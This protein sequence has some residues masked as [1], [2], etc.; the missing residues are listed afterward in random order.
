MEKLHEESAREQAERV[1]EMNSALSSAVSKRFRENQRLLREVADHRIHRQNI[2]LSMFWRLTRPLRKVFGEV[3]GASSHARVIEEGGF[4]NSLVSKVFTPRSGGVMP[5]EGPSFSI[6]MLTKNTAEADLIE[7]VESVV[8]QSY[9]RWELLI[10]DNGSTDRICKA[11][12]NEIARADDRITVRLGAE[13]ALPAC[14]ALASG[15]YVV[16]LQESQLLAAGALSALAEALGRNSEAREIRGNCE[17]L[18][19]GEPSGAFRAIRRSSA[20]G[21]STVEAEGVVCY[22]RP[23]MVAAPHEEPDPLNEDQACMRFWAFHRAAGLLR[24]SYCAY[25]QLI[26]EAG[27]EADNRKLVEES[28][29]WRMSGPLRRTLTKNPRMLRGVRPVAGRI[30]RKVRGG[31]T[32]SPVSSAHPIDCHG[33]PGRLSQAKERQL[34]EVALR[35]PANA[36]VAEEG[37]LSPTFSVIVP[38][39]NTPEAYLREC[40]ESV[41]NQTY[42]RWELCLWDDGSTKPDVARVLKEYE[43][44]DPRIKCFTNNPNQGIAGASESCF[45]ASTGEFLA[46]LDNDDI[47]MP[48]ALS[49]IVAALRENPDADYLYTDHAMMMGD[50]RVTYASLKRDWSPE[51]FLS[52]NYIVHLKA[53]RRTVFEKAGTFRGMDNMITDL[54]LTIRMLEAGAKIVHVPEIAYGWRIHEASVADS[55][56]RKPEIHRQALAAISKH[57]ADDGVPAKLTYPPQLQFFGVG[58]YKLEFDKAALKKSAIVVPVRG[59]RILES[60][61]FDSLADTDIDQIP[62]VHFIAL[63]QEL[64]P[65]HRKRTHMHF[66]P[67]Q[68]E[69]DEIMRGIDAEALVFVSDSARFSSANW[70]REVLGFLAVSPSIGAVGGMVLD[71][72]LNVEE[73]GTLLKPGLP[74]MYKGQPSC[75]T[76][77]WFENTL[78]TNVEAVSSLL[79]AT[80]KS[81]YEQ[82]GGMPVHEY[83]DNA[84]VAY[85][86][87]LRMAGYRLVLNPWSKIVTLR[88][89]KVRADLEQRLKEQFGE[90]CLNDRYYHPQFDGGG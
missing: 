6:L 38:C 66:A 11:L 12:L 43:A 10:C 51:F 16:T 24:D 17:D 30:L 34:L 70:L 13:A 2:E 84:G 28:V 22:S 26:E 74:T 32:Q 73:G 39:Y 29:Y 62:E 61:F 1:R 69:F 9:P 81:V 82:V 57:L 64:T 41:R 85:G 50:G 87:R 36:A 86:L 49:A 63:D 33:I 54:Q 72:W 53:V 18:D 78:A 55:P 20:G 25:W 80:P 3:K 4:G 79:M 88:P 71:P 68:T 46:L 40:I 47:L 44:L 31:P 75:E 8:S 21:D 7:A 77:F 52:T 76:G 58:I 37:K 48:G 60:S 5:S 83:G 19:S 45:E 67:S 35:P 89:S 59:S 42:D 14:E 56:T 23:R 65:L 90:D 27:R 15:D